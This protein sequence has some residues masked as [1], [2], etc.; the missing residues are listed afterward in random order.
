MPEGLSKASWKVKADKTRSTDDK[1]KVLRF[2]CDGGLTFLPYDCQLDSQVAVAEIL[3][4]TVFASRLY[5]RCGG[6]EKINRKRK[7]IA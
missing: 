6:Y 4:F 2:P 3:M 7:K 1:Q 5:R